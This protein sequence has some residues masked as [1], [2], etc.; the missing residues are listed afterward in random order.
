[1]D[2]A[3]LALLL[4][5]D[6]T[7]VNLGRDAAFTARIRARRVPPTPQRPQGLDYALTLHGPDGR[8]L[9][10]FDNAHPVRRGGGPGGK[11]GARHD[12][13]HR[14]DRVAPYDYRDAAALLADFWAAVDAFLKERGVEA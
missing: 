13:R 7:V 5:L 3:G 12:H 1:M 10:G 2:E 4:E 9:L 8:R 14:L 6:G 11:A